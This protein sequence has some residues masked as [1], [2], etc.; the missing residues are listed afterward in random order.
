MCRRLHGALGVSRR[1][2]VTRSAV[3]RIPRRKFTET[4]QPLQRAC[5]TAAETAAS[6]TLIGNSWPATL[7]SVTSGLTDKFDA[8]AM[9]L[10]LLIMPSF[11]LNT[12]NSIKSMP[13]TMQTPPGI[14]ST[15]AG[16]DLA[17][18][19]EL[20][21]SLRRSW[22]RGRKYLL[23]AVREHSSRCQTQMETGRPLQVWR[24]RWNCVMQCHSSPDGRS[25]PASAGT[26]AKQIL[27]L[28]GISPARSATA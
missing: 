9:P 12:D 2:A 3:G 10:K 4:V 14:T 16:H 11:N 19:P 24:T 18:H 7:L 25:I 22:R 26:R 6:A 20:E 13:E 23:S 8:I 28:T 21:I 5:C 1:P 17:G 15:A 27:Q